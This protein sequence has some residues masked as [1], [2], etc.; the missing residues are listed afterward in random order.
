MIIW[1]EVNI[2][3]Y[4]NQFFIM[5]LKEIGGEVKSGGVRA[6]FPPEGRKL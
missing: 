6:P 3:I 4:M 5:A 1:S 2:N